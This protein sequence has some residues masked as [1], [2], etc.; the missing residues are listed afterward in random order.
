MPDAETSVNESSEWVECAFSNDDEAECDISGGG[1]GGGGGGE[2]GDTFTCSLCLET[3]VNI[4]RIGC[5][6]HGACLVCFLECLSRAT[7]PMDVFAFVL[8]GE[9]CA[10]RP[11]DCGRTVVNYPLD[12]LHTYLQMKHT[13]YLTRKSGTIGLF[14]RLCGAKQTHFPCDCSLCCKLQFSKNGKF[15]VETMHLLAEMYLYLEELVAHCRMYEPVPDG[16][17]MS[18]RERLKL[19]R[20]ALSNTKTLISVVNDKSGKRTDVEWCT[21]CGFS[22]EPMRGGHCDHSNLFSLFNLIS[23]THARCFTDRGELKTYIKHISLE[24]LYIALHA[25]LDTLLYT[26]CGGCG[27]VLEHV[28]ACCH[29]TCELC[30]QHMCALCNSVI[31]GVAADHY[32]TSDAF[33]H[34][35]SSIERKCPQFPNYVFD[36]IPIQRHTKRNVGYTKHV[37]VEPIDQFYQKRI[38]KALNDIPDT[39]ARDLWTL[40]RVWVFSWIMQLFGSTRLNK[41]LKMEQVLKHRGLR[42]LCY[43]VCGEDILWVDGVPTMGTDSIPESI[44]L[45]GEVLVGNLRAIPCVEE[46]HEVSEP[47]DKRWHFARG[48]GEMFSFK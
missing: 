23:K 20:Y 29:L 11:Q 27:S 34:D 5:T 24:K 25:T 2:D 8:A 9:C 37:S 18:L 40:K 4:H 39:H 22:Q 30:G 7:L 17:S 48:N 44:V 31:N 10:I 13:H 41:L 21:L 26:K 6:M 15:L 19:R 32:T 12:A 36:W 45:C 28:S 33:P 38:A 35:F 46:I 14:K 16:W 43:A 47:D 1:G 3:H 42:D